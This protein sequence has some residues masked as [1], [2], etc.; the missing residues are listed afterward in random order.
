MWTSHLQAVVCEEKL[1][2][3]LAWHPTFVVL[4]PRSL[5]SPIKEGWLWFGASRNSL[6][7]SSSSPP[8]SILHVEAT[9][10]ETLNF[11]LGPLCLLSL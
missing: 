2:P 8:K 9:W 5:Q 6:G 10:R 1:L 7:S 4:P 3:H 11:W